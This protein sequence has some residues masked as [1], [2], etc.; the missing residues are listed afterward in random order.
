VDQEG[1]FFNGY[2]VLGN[3]RG[4]D[5]QAVYPLTAIVIFPSP[6]NTI[7]VI[8]GSYDRQSVAAGAITALKG[9]ALG[10]K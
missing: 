5:D 7:R 3:L 10:V 1:Q 6:P 2:T 4:H 9:N 8:C